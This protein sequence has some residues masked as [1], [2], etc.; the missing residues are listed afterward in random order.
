MKK[1]ILFL[2]SI[3]L[4]SCAEDVVEKPE[5]LLPKDKMAS[6]FYDLALVNAAKNTGNDILK[7]NNIETMN[8]IFTKHDIDSVAFVDSD[9]YYA[10]KPAIYKEIYEDV[11]LRLKDVKD[12]RDEEKKQER[13]KDSIARAEKL[14]KKE[15]SALKKD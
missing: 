7:K 12:K 13:K 6:I 14:L 1:Y 4:L 5:N 15:N 3:C 10:S 2:I 9:L 11:E 8:Y